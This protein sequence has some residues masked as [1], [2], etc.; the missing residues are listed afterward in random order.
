MGLELVLGIGAFLLGVALVIGSAEKLVQG[1]VGVSLAFRVST[2]ILAVLLVGFDAENLAVGADAASRGLPGVA[3]GTVIGSSMVAVAFAV[4]IT[5]L[6]VPIKVEL[7]RKGVLLIGPLAVAAAWLLSLD[8]ALSRIDGVVLLAVF[9]GLV[10]YLFREG[11]RGLVMKG[12][13]DE[14]IREVQREHH[15]KVFYLGLVVATLVGLAVGAGL[16]GFD[17]KRILSTWGLSGTVFGMTI[18][19]FA[20]SAEE[21]ARSLIPALK[22]H[23]EITL[24][25]VIGSAAYFFTFNA[26]LIALTSPIAVDG[27]AR[28]SYYGFALAATGLVGVLALKGNISR[29]GGMALMVLYLAFV[30]TVV[31]TGGAA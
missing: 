20:V 9:A 23:A 25:N 27:D 11:R 1:L 24:G 14:A 18:V 17:S 12:E 7:S 21:L 16:V 26:G 6:V 30:A 13:A 5:A 19:A 3:L 8:G 4:G 15:G 22:G 29:W 28:W 2:F 10:W 31:L